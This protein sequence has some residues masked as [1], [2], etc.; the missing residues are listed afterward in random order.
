MKKFLNYKTRQNKLRGMNATSLINDKCLQTL[1]S[2]AVLKHLHMCKYYICC[3]D[4]YLINY[5]V[6]VC[7]NKNVVLTGPKETAICTDI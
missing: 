2:N 4:K 6:Q 1:Y 7:L 3:S 5:C